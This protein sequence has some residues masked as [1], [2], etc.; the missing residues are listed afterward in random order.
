MLND[1]VAQKNRTSKKKK[2]PS[3]AS[4]IHAHNQNSSDQKYSSVSVSQE[5]TTL[6]K[7]FEDSRKVARASADEIAEKDI[8]EHKKA[9]IALQ[10]N[11][12]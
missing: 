11:G 9:D 5:K 10:I 6:S 4:T 2:A 7:D 3:R 8:E 12:V 1:S